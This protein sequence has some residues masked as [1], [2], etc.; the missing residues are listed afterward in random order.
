[1]R[2]ILAGCGRGGRSATATWMSRFAPRG[3]VAWLG[4]VA[5]RRARGAWYEGC[6]RV[7]VPTM[8]VCLAGTGCLYIEPTWKGNVS[9]TIIVPSEESPVERPL[10]TL[11]LTVVAEDP[12]SQKF[13]CFWQLFGQVLPGDTCDKEPNGPF[14]FTTLTLEEW[15]PLELEGE[16]IS[17]Q[18]R[19]EESGKAAE[20]SFLLVAPQGEFE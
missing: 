8:W 19:D 2:R 11:V 15:D 1:M 5:Q 4:Q 12:D 3:A 13:W 16:T 10:D 9:P 6:I 7:W 20:V 14:I 17:V 18:V